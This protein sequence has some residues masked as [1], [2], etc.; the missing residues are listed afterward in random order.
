MTMVWLGVAV[1]VLVGDAAA[2]KATII[3]SEPTNLGPVI[4]DA[5]DM[6]ECDFSHDGLELYF[7]S[8]RPGGYGLKDIW[9]ARRD[10]LD[11]PWQE[12]VNLG[13]NVNSPGGEL[14]PSIS[15]D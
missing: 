10:T 4:N 9:V 5:T 14:E 3:M 15:G 1:G 12:P 13:P 7:S 2:V 8:G 11:S 6:Q